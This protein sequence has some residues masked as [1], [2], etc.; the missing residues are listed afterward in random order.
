MTFLFGLYSPTSFSIRLLKDCHAWAMTVD[1]VGLYRIALHNRKYFQTEWKLKPKIFI[2]PN[3]KWLRTCMG[4]AD[5]DMDSSYVDGQI[6]KLSNSWLCC[7]S[8]AIFW[9]LKKKRSFL[10][11]CRQAYGKERLVLESVR[12]PIIRIHL[13]GCDGDPHVTSTVKW[14][15]KQR[16]NG[17]LSKTI[18]AWF[19]NISTWL[20]G[21]PVSSRCA[22]FWITQI[23]PTATNMAVDHNPISLLQL[24]WYSLGIAG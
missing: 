19:F 12:G 15:G 14:T 1:R 18:M 10:C 9:T 16:V 6:L 7:G 11:N 13:A 22:S 21:K 8:A 17:F 5:K 4:L 20:V 24:P 23:P 2:V 3:I